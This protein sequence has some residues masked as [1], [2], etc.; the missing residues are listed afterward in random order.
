MEGTI[1]K[2]NKGFTLL[3]VLVAASIFAIVMTAASG[4]FTSALHNQGRVLTEQMAISNSSYALE[5]M[6]RSMRMAVKDKSGDCLDDY[7]DGGTCNYAVSDDG[8]AIRFLN[9]DKKCV[10]FFEDGG[11]IKIKKSATTT[12]NFNGGHPFTSDELNI[13]DLTFK[14]EGECQDD[15]L[16]PAVVIKIQAEIDDKTTFNTQTTVTQRNLD[17]PK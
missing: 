8:S 9:H 15:M 14:L 6:S 4:I 2:F 3:E 12:D 13:K 17:V 7:L 5:Y 10:E 11:Q 1:N 16:Q